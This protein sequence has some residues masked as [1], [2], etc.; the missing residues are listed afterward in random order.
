[1]ASDKK[2]KSIE[3][4]DGNLRREK[5]PTHMFCPHYLAMDISLYMWKLRGTLFSW[6]IS[7]WTAALAHFYTIS[8][9]EILVQK[10]RT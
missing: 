9:Q 2:E 7:H 6:I 5:I 1:L 10:A 8:K 4:G 3:E